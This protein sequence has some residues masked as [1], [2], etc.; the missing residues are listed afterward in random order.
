MDVVL[1][2]VTAAKLKI[3]SSSTST[4]LICHD[5]RPNDELRFRNMTILKRTRKNDSIDAAQYTPTH[6]TNEKKIQE[7]RLKTKKKI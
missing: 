7:K 3:V 2:K 1:Q 5:G 4:S 6:H